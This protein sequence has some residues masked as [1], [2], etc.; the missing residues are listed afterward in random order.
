MSERKE[1]RKTQRKVSFQICL[2]RPTECH[3]LSSILL[4]PHPILFSDALGDHPDSAER[5]EREREQRE[6][7]REAEREQR[8]SRESIERGRERERA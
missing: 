5:A 7:E 3:S 1:K 8:E 4:S 6:R 2:T